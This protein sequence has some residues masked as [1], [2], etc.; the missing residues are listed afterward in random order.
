MANDVL[1]ALWTSA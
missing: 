1:A